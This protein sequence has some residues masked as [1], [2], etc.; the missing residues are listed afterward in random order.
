[1]TAAVNPNTAHVVALSGGKDST[2]MALR[3]AEIEPREYR[4]I[5]TPTGDE[6]PEM[7]D[8]WNH[9]GELL[10]TRI[11]PVMAG[12]LYSIIDDQ[13]AIP[14]W[15][16]R[17]C[18]RILKIAPYSEYLAGL[19][20]QFDRVV[21]YVGLRADESEREGGDYSSIPDVEMRF[22]MREWGWG[23]ADVFAYLD[24]RC[25]EVPDRT[26][27]A[28]CFYQR[29]DEWWKLWKNHPEKYARGEAIEERMGHTFRSDGRDTHPAQ[30]KLLRERFE[31]GFVPPKAQPTLFEMTKCRVCRI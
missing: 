17:F 14:N 30:L 22:P 28:L 2:A 13:G 11:T 16:M 15:R 10:G 5:C 1:M 21:S 23:I 12:T 29:L 9:L 18:T 4:Y 31:R 3:L 20:S 27:C 25:V 24:S 26:D 7:F 6:L 8:H 19:S